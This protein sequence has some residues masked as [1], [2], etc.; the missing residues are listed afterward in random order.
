MLSFIF[1]GLRQRFG[2]LLVAS[3]VP[4]AAFGGLIAVDQLLPSAAESDSRTGFRWLMLVLALLLPACHGF[5]W[6]VSAAFLADQTDRKSLGWRLSLPLSFVSIRSLWV[7]MGWTLL[8]VFIFIG[9]GMLLIGL[10]AYRDPG[11]LVASTVQ[12]AQEY[13]DGTRIAPERGAG[14]QS[15]RS[16]DFNQPLLLI[17]TSLCALGALWI[18][19]KSLMCVPCVCSG[20]QSICLLHWIV[21]PVGV[22]SG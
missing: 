16:E 4:L 2:I 10:L 12:Q 11:E 22:V 19:L 13:G 9:A 20:S 14:G 21:R 6:S 8:V 17:F 7:T 15:V 1:S 5:L 3:L 18:W